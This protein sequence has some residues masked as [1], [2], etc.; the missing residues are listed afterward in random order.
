MIRYLTCVL[1]ALAALMISYPGQAADGAK[2]YAPD[3]GDFKGL[4]QLRYFK[5]WCAGRS[6]N[7]QLAEY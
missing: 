4:T 2:T 6:R 7:W 1:A 5:L 3:L